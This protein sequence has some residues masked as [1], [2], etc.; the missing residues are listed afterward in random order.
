MKQHKWT[1]T[2]AKKKKSKSKGKKRK[3]I[4]YL[5]AA[6]EDN[7]ALAGAKGLLPNSAPEQFLLGLLGGAGVAYVLSDEQLRRQIIRYGVQTYDS[8]AGGLAEL[9]EEA[10]DA[11]AELRAK[12][13][14]GS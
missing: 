10:A 2:V 3:Q 1:E 6:R 11:H 13:A 8:I 7:G 5:S 4:Y 9:K 12:Q 14:A